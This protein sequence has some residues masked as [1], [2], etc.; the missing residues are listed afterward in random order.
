MLLSSSFFNASALCTKAPHP[1]LQLPSSTLPCK[2]TTFVGQ[3]HLDQDLVKLWSHLDLAR[4]RLRQTQTGD[5][6]QDRVCTVRLVRGRCRVQ[7]E[8]PSHDANHLC[9]VQVGHTCQELHQRCSL[10]WVLERLAS[11]FQLLLHRFTAAL[12]RPE[13]GVVQLAKSN[14]AWFLCILALVLQA[15]PL[16]V[17]RLGAAL[18]VWI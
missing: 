14:A 8:A 4:K 5:C 17:R 13:L 2:T 11:S 18:G 15:P 9:L 6:C 7:L 16:R 1:V 12:Q 10:G 3:P